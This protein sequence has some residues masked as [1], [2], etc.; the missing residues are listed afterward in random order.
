MKFM[1]WSAF[2][3]TFYGMFVECSWGVQSVLWVFA[4]LEMTGF[5]WLHKLDSEVLSLAV[6]CQLT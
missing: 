3:L 1:R 6:P 5:Q 4:F 2:N